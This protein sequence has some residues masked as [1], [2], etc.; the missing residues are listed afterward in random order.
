MRPASHHTPSLVVAPLAQDGKPSEVIHGVVLRV[1]S[2]AESEA[3]AERERDSLEA[4]RRTVAMQLRSVNEQFVAERSSSSNRMEQVL[5]Q[6]L[7]QRKNLK[8]N[9]QRKII[10]KKRKLKKVK[11]KLK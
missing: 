5:R 2:A 10:K 1:R 6:N 11:K 4:Q 9:N 8:R 3:D 7:M